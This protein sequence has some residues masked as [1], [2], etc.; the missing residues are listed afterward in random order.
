[1][2]YQLHLPITTGICLDGNPLSVLAGNIFLFS[3]E[4]LDVKLLPVTAKKGKSFIDRTT[5][6]LQTPQEKRFELRKTKNINLQTVKA[7]CWKATKAKR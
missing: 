7:C 1:V 6:R 5:A 3:D 4:Y 2:S